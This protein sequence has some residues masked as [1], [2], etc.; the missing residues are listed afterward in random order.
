MVATAYANVKVHTIIEVLSRY[1]T[2]ISGHP[3]NN[4]VFEDY[5]ICAELRC[6][7]TH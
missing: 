6:V 4:V 5:F 3:I 7:L 1:D 2:S